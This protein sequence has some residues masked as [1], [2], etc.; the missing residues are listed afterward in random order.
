MICETCNVWHCVRIFIC[1]CNAYKPFSSILL[2]RFGAECVLQSTGYPIKHVPWLCNTQSLSTSVFRM[3]AREIHNCNW[4]RC[5]CDILNIQKKKE[6]KMEKKK[7]EEKKNSINLFAFV[8]R[9][10]NIVYYVLCIFLACL[11]WWL[12]AIF[13]NKSNC[14][15]RLTKYKNRSV[16]S[17]HLTNVT[18]NTRRQKHKIAISVHVH[19]IFYVQLLLLYPNMMLSL[20]IKW[21][22]VDAFFMGLFLSDVIFFLSL[23]L[24][25]NQCQPFK[26]HLYWLL[27][28]VSTVI[29]AEQSISI[30]QNH[31]RI[32]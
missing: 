26:R 5:P 16:D 25:G 2:I 1:V 24:V 9:K 19:H 31:S 7:N 17:H 3:S 30:L 15:W 22:H 13:M 27:T 28:I 4:S 14:W 10:N 6:M 21:F 23:P 29:L 12:K 8:E 20:S 32:N 18:T 11:V